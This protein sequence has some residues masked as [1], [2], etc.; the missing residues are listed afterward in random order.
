[1]CLRKHTHMHARHIHT[2]SR[3]NTHKVMTARP[4]TSR[5]RP[6]CAVILWAYVKICHEFTNISTRHGKQA[7]SSATFFFYVAWKGRCT[8][9][10]LMLCLRVS[11][12]FKYASAVDL[13]TAETAGACVIALHDAIAAC[14][15]CW[16]A[17]VRCNLARHAR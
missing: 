10:V 7:I 13:S 16:L 5:S 15:T 4:R 17:S 8:S 9:L 12:Y 3:T 1:M 6:C 14:H 11:W 2:R